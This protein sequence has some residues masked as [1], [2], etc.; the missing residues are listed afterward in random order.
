MSSVERIEF[1]DDVTCATEWLRARMSGGQ[2]VVVV[3]GGDDC[4]RCSNEFFIENWPDLFVPS[5]DDA[6]VYSTS[7]PF[8]LFYCHETE[9]EI[10]RRV[11]FD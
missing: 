3:L 7:S 5:R 8:V 9:F 1:G 10:G 6:M 11:V 2:E 4:F